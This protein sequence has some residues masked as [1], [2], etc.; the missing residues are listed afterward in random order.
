MALSDWS[1][2]GNYL[3]YAA[4]GDVWAL[5]W[6]GARKPLQL[7]TTPVFEEGGPVF[8]PDGRWIAY[9]SGESSSVTRSGTG[10]VFV[11]SFPQRGFTRQVSP[12]GFAAR[13][14][15]DGRSFYVAPTTC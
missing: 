2:D 6:S 13:W 3:A 9:Q 14:S 11:Q 5:P 15:G 8:S 12:P 7:T 1:R 4:R 10:D